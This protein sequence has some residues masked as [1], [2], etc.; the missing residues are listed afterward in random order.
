V[1]ASLSLFFIFGAGGTQLTWEKGRRRGGCV[2]WWEKRWVSDVR[3]ENLTGPKF[4]SM[5]LSPIIY[6]MFIIFF[7]FFE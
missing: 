5:T 4:Y 3:N 2:W 1:P 6:A 7:F